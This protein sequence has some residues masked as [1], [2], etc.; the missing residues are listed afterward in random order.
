MGP[1]VEAWLLHR[2]IGMKV[3]TSMPASLSKLLKKRIHNKTKL[4]LFLINHYF[5]N[6]Y[7][8][9]ATVRTCWDDR[10]EDAIGLQGGRKSDIVRHFFR[11]FIATRVQAQ[12]ASWGIMQS[13]VVERLGRGGGN[14]QQL[15]AVRDGDL[16]YS[17]LPQVACGP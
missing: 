1:L 4:T 2:S 13:F 7:L 9:L 14:H 16:I 5:D 17:E 11:P 12:P 3:L 6:I 15:S 10:Q 8:G